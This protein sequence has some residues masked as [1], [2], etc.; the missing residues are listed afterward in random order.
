MEVKDVLAFLKLIANKH[1]S[2]SFKRILKRF[3]FGI[4][5]KT[6]S[7]IESETY[8][9]LGIVLSDFIEDITPSKEYFSMLVEELNNDNIVVFDVESTGVDVTE[10]EIV[11]IAAIKINSNGETIETFE[12]F[13]SPTKSVKDSYHVH[14]FSDEYLR[15]NGEDKVKVLNE[16]IEFS[17]DAVIVGHNVQFDINILSSELLRC[18][19][20][21]P[22]FKGFYDTLD[23]YRR[24]HSNLE[25]HKLETLS[26]I[27]KTKHAPSH[28]AMDDILATGELLVIAVN[29][30]IKKTSDR[31]I[32]CMG[33][34]IRAF[35]SVKE[36]L[37][38]V[39]DFSKHKR[40]QDIVAFIVKEL[41]LSSVYKGE[42]GENK[43]EKLRD[44]Y[45]LLKDLDDSSK[46]NR[47]AILD[48]LKIT[49]LSNGDLENIIIKRSNKIRI[50]IITVHQAKGLEYEN[51][52]IAGLQ[53]GKFPSYRAIK[54]SDLD[55]EK[56]TFY[57]AITRAKK[58]LYLSYNIDA[59][60]GRR[61]TKSRFVD[62]L[63]SRLLSYK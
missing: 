63:P 13:I 24:F 12:K 35:S 51:V 5:E 48:V 45:V 56:R 19:L 32:K 18:K 2:V 9:S 6:I 42:D 29:E 60:F 4:G 62:L 22:K 1:D 61:A 52:F 31:R 28:N 38:E 16:F 10:D 44:F 58:R 36:V 54:C 21:G 30:S 39:F 34:H 27:F 8:K 50:P 47:D 17:K 14:G 3:P 49:S 59:G 33:N 20:G 43:I 55:E 11:Q 46:N 57:V 40:P 37:K 23:I 26:R 53:E 41:N 25:N 15:E 7:E